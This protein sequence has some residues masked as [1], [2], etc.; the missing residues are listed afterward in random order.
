MNVLHF[1]GIDVAKKK[2][3]VAYL[4]DKERQMVKTKVL[5]N[6]L[7]GFNQLLDWI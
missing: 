7:A 2:F 1:I 6:K 4:K 5:E 3:D